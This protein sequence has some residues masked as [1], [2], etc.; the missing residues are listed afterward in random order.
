M[1]SR[2]NPDVQIMRILRASATNTLQTE[3]CSKS[4]ALPS[5]AAELKSEREWLRQLLLDFKSKVA[6]TP[7]CS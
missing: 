1:P 3:E 2:K 5:R 7:D 4:K 6:Q